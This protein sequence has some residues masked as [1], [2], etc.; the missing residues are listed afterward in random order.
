MSWTQVLNCLKWQQFQTS[1]SYVSIM[2]FVF[3][4][5]FALWSVF[6]S[7]RRWPNVSKVTIVYLKLFSKCLFWCHVS[8]SSSQGSAFEGVLKMHFVFV[9]FCQIMSSHH[10]DQMSQFSKV[11]R[12]ALW[13]CSLNVLVVVIVFVFI[14]AFVIFFWASYVSSLL[15]S[16]VSKVTRL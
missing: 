16:N 3:V 13:R 4:F 12:I 7:S 8:S 5:V 2:V 14:F 15:W 9:F 10:S 11:S 6:A 1:I